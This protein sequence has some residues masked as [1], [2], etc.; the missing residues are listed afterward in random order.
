MF[1]VFRIMKIHDQKMWR[2]MQYCGEQA[3]RTKSV[4]GDISHTYLPHYILNV[5]VSMCLETA[6]KYDIRLKIESPLVLK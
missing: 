6:E 1:G 5:Y 3:N 4:G 2:N